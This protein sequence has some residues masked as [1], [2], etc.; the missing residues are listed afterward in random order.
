MLLSHRHF[1]C[2]LLALAIGFWL[3]GAVQARPDLERRIGVT[4]A[5]SDSADY[6]FSD[7]RF[8]S[9]DGQ[10]R[11]RV[12]IAQPRRAPAPDGYPTI[13]FLDGNAVLMELNA[14]LLARLATAKRPPVLVMIGYD[15]DLRIDAAG[16]AYDYTLPLPTG[17][18]KPPQA[19][20]GAEAFLQLIE[21][22]IKPAIAAKLVVDQQRQT[23]WGHS[24]GGLFVLHTLF[25]HPAAFQHYIAVEPSLWW[26]NGM[27]LQEAQQWAERHPTPAAKLQ[28]WVGLAERE[29]A[30][31]PGVKSPALPANAAQMLAERLAKLDGLTVGYR[32]WPGLGHGA[33][34]GA[35]IEPAL[36]SVAYED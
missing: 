18:K 2:T 14:S 35:A 28:L 29:R 10:R 25:A 6:R 17:M 22:Q 4:V 33:M 15:N 23:L 8:T 12:R 19:G 13:Y 27:I 31:P 24:Y 21:T 16:R 30:A 20:G 7:L 5:D 1:I 26:G 36:S 34:L 3:P 32:E 11:Y 9:A